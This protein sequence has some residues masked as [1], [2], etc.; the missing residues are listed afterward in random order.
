M[1]RRVFYSFHYKPDAWRASQVRNIGAVEGNRPA[2]D[3]DWETVKRGGDAA[4]RR[5]ISGQMGGR[6]CT[7][8]LVGTNTA[9]R[10]WITHEIVESWNEEMG[11]AGIHIHGLADQHGVTKK[12]GNPFEHVSFNG[13]RLSSVVKCHDPPGGDSRAK[14][15]WISNYLAD[16]IEAAIDIRR[17]FR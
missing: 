2:T 7:I 15:G 3:N 6:S 17:N 11:V 14:Y 10:K 1:K 13:G 16:I 4:I 8:V 12:G 9:G 5:W